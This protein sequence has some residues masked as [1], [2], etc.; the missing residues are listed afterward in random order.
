MNN[1]FMNEKQLHAIIKRYPFYVNTDI[2]LKVKNDA[3]HI[4]MTWDVSKSIKFIKIELLA[5]NYQHINQIGYVQN[6][7]NIHPLT[8]SL[9]RVINTKEDE[10][11]DYDHK[12]N[13]S[14][15]FQN[16]INLAMNRMNEE[17]DKWVNAE[18]HISVL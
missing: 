15:L 13:K 1:I 8:F 14:E 9:L 17:F 3:K 11:Y 10:S 18:D 7:K 5:F 12:L 4:E 6:N 2:S 16:W